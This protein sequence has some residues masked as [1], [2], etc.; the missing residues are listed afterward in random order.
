[1]NNKYSSSVL[2]D[3]LQ[4]RPQ[5]IWTVC[6]SKGKR[7]EETDSIS[8]RGGSRKVGVVQGGYALR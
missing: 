5:I 1:M 2:G 8:P 6:L 7:R 4:L 3:G